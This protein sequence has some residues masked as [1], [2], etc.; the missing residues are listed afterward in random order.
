MRGHQAC[1]ALLLLALSIA[2]PSVKAT[3]K[4]PE[5]CW[6]QCFRVSESENSFYKFVILIGA[7][8]TPAI[9]A[10]CFNKVLLR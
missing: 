7:L 8:V 4:C 6:E 9:L 5:A 1:M 2:I 10:Q 3:D